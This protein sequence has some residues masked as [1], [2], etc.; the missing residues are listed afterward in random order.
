ML[1]K[2]LLAIIFLPVIGI[3]ILIFVT[4]KEKRLL[5]LITFDICG[6]SFINVLF[7]VLFFDKSSSKFQYLNNIEFITFLNINLNIGVDGISILFLLLINMLIP[8]SIIFSWNVI[9][10]KLKLFLI[11]LLLLNF[12]LNNVFSS[13]DLLSFYIFFESTLIPMFLIIGIWGSRERKILAAYYFFLY[14][15]F[16]SIF[17]LLGI[18]YIFEQVGTTQYEILLTFSFSKIEQKMLWFSFFLSFSNKVPMV[19]FHLWLPE[20]HVEAPTIG[21]V[22]LAGILL[23]LGSYGFLRFSLP[24]L[25]FGCFFF[26]PFVYFIGTVSVIHSSFVAIR[27]T[28]LKRIIAYTSIAHMNLIILGIFS[29]NIIGLQGSIF[30]SLSHGFIASGLFFLIGVLYDRFKTRI[31]YYYGG[32]STIMPIFVCFFIFFNL[33]NMGFPC[34]SS[35]IGELLLFFGL[36]QINNIVLVLCATSLIISGVYSLWIFNR[37][38]YGNI[39]MLYINNF[40]DID[41]KEFFII[42]PLCFFS[43]IS[44]LYSNLFLNFIIL[45]V[46]FIIEMLN[47]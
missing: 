20:A 24:L 7:L 17:M 31:I 41:F 6:F 26:S 3:I 38:V 10:T 40:L 22:L 9:K 30:Q 15:L 42:F 1:N 37:L 45:N 19:P 21:S 44:G 28:D 13:I 11:L 5:K 18:A 39:K 46:Y 47:L 14:T 2:L 16:G 35:F 23:K 32:L 33:A 43:L 8:I 27:Q 29:F 4:N 25:P 34:T 36:G 12:F